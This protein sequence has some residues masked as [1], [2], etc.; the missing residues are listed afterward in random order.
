MCPVI[1][2]ISDSTF[3]YQHGNDPQMGGFGW[4][5]FFKWFPVPKREQVRRKGDATM[6]VR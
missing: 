4:S 5:L 1:D 3:A 2:V 6:P